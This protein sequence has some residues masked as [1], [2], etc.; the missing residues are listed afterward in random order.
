MKS[1]ST[2]QVPDTNFGPGE[3]G[4]WHR[5]PATK[6]FSVGQE[7]AGKHPVANFTPKQEM[8]FQTRHVPGTA[9]GSLCT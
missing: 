5:A 9:L 6:K 8:L 4:D 2:S 7:G 3:T 1:P